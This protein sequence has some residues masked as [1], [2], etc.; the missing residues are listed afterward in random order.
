MF[1]V[2]L[3]GSVVSPDFKNARYLQGS[4]DVTVN[5]R[6]SEMLGLGMDTFAFVHHRIEAVGDFVGRY[7][8]YGDAEGT[9][10]VSR[11]STILRNQHG[12]GEGSC[13]RQ[14]S[15]IQGPP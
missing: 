14:L 6:V 9:Y 7:G 8:V 1:H 3:G 5:D 12:S 10:V 15:S 2:D 13:I 4:P 11:A